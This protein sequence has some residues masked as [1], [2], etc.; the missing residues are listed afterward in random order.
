MF[1]VVQQV[2]QTS[3]LLDIS[4]FNHSFDNFH[5]NDLNIYFEFSKKFIFIFLS[6]KYETWNNFQLYQIDDWKYRKPIY[7]TKL[8]GKV[9]CICEV[10]KHIVCWIFFLKVRNSNLNHEW[11]FLILKPHCLQNSSAY[12][13]KIF[14]RIILQFLLFY[15]FILCSAVQNK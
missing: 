3:Y 13:R 5:F 4:L 2:L 1:F 9:I 8:F 15:L 11:G 7:L 10:I 6:I 12:F 14:M